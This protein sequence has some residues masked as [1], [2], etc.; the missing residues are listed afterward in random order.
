MEL[1]VDMTSF[2]KR[3]AIIEMAINQEKGVT[4]VEIEDL[5]FLSQGAV[6]GI[7]REL[8]DTGFIERI[9]SHNYV[10]Y[11]ATDKSKALF[12]F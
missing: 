10:V 7:L 1:V 6:L 3:L 12:K 8:Q 4:R 2:E 5:I 11:V 9:W